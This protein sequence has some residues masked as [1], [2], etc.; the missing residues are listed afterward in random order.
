MYEPTPA[1]KDLHK[2]QEE[3][4]EKTKNMTVEAKIAYIRRKAEEAKNKYGLHLRKTAHI[5]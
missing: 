3:I 5:K 1:M 4:Y 2:I